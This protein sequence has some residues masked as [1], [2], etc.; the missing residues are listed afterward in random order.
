MKAD[1][2]R[3]QEEHPGE[4][5]PDDVAERWDRTNKTIDEYKKR[6]RACPPR[7]AHGG[8]EAH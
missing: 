5:F 2:K 4:E 7:R 1:L 6:M 8:V 3:M